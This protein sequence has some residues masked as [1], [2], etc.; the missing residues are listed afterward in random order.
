MGQKVDETHVHRSA[1][2]C[3]TTGIDTG[4]IINSMILAK[5]YHNMHD[6]AGSQSPSAVIKAILNKTDL[7]T[8]PEKTALDLMDH[9]VKE[10]CSYNKLLLTTAQDANPVKFI[11]QVPPQKPAVTVAAIVLAAGFSKR[12]GED[13]LNLKLGDGTVFEATIQ[14][15]TKAGF[16]QV[17]VVTRPGS[18]LA[19]QART[20]NCHLVENLNPEEGLSSSLKAGLKALDSTIQGALF[21]LADQPLITPELYILLSNSYRKKLK[22]V[23]CPLYKGKRGNPTIFDRRTWPTLEQIEGDQGGRSL[24]DKLAEEQIDYITVDDPAVITDLDTPADYAR[25]RDQDN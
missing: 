4:K 24:L 3:T 10:T 13:K 17:I 7:L 5:S 23:T 6:I 9:L 18:N 22:L 21:A 2:F 20:Y 16:Q 11:L 12:M 14:A 8:E 1:Q 25:L 19:D 15:I